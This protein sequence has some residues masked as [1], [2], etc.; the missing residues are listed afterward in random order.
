MSIIDR[1]QSATVS[2]QSFG[3]TT[4]VLWR[5]LVIENPMIIEVSRFRR[6]FLEGGRGKSVNT[7]ILILAIVAYAALLLVIANLSG[8][9]PP[10]A[11]IF[12]QTGVFCFLAPALTFGAIA[13]E[14][15]K[16]SWDL[17]LAAPITHAQI[18]MG[19]F[20]AAAAGIFGAL[21]LFLVPTMFTALTYKGDWNSYGNQ[22]DGVVSGT[23]ALIG[24]EIIS[25]SF[26]LMIAAMALLFSARCRRG[27][28]ALGIVLG[29]L[30]VALIAMPMLLGLMTSGTGM[31]DL[32]TVS[33]PFMAINRL[34]ELRHLSASSGYSG[35][36]DYHILGGL[37]YGF[38]QGILYLSGTAVF[39]VW[40]IKTVTFADGEKKFIPRKPHA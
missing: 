34:E 17:L 35:I 18:I 16:R 37:W 4:A 7:T 13:G 21:L 26:A 19:K 40:A 14:R 8:D 11:L 23:Y 5:N 9:F 25:V 27:L 39:L 12:L 33:H 15:E 2:Q 36:D 32:V 29:A 31:S 10:V 6:R 1:P 28:M 30:F 22:A 3:S 38:V 20:M 24:Q